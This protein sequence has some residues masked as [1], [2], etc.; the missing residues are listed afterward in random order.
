MSYT[1]FLGDTFEDEHDEELTRK[2]GDTYKFF[3]NKYPYLYK[4]PSQDIQGIFNEFKKSPYGD[5]F[6]KSVERTNQYINQ[7]MPEWKIKYINPRKQPLNDLQP[8]NQESSDFSFKMN[9]PFTYSQLST[10]N[11]SNTKTG[12]DIDSNI[13]TS[14]PEV[15]RHHMHLSGFPNR[16]WENKTNFKAYFPN[17]IRKKVNKN[18]LI[19]DCVDSPRYQEFITNT[20]R[21]EGIGLANVEEP[22]MTGIRQSTLNDILRKYPSFRGVYPE[23]I[24]DLTQDQWRNI[25]CQ[26]YYKLPHGELINHPRLRDMILDQNVMRD[27]TKFVKNLQQMLN[28]Y[29]ITVEVDGVLGSQT[30]N[31]L[32]SL[33]DPDDFV[34]YAKEKLPDFLSKKPEYQNGWK[35]RIKKY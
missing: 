16:N 21:R 32:N 35:N 11:N 10:E 23:N 7:H 5:T 8:I 25:Y 34:D 4:L 26:E 9:T 29:G 22:T 14:E 17:P 12:T 28:N 2:F 3:K 15:Y 20:E 27:R 13:S 19:N 18:P 30:V 33:K 6:E 24:K 1:T 31:I